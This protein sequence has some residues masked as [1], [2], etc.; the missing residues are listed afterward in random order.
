VVLI[1]KFVLRGKNIDMK[2][3]NMFKKGD[4]VICVDDKVDH[5]EWI[6]SGKIR[7]GTIYTVRSIRH[8][9]SI[10]NEGVRLEE[11]LQDIHP[12]LNEE[13][14]FKVERFRKLWNDEK[15]KTFNKERVLEKV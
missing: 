4:K 12:I 6:I 13:Y 3:N 2:E 9:D 5:P 15:L 11:V 10:A 1:I 14:I 8:R 7:N